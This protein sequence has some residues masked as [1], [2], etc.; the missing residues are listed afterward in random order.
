METLKRFNQITL[1]ALVIAFALAS[2]Q[3]GQQKSTEAHDEVA[4]EQETTEQQTVTV[5]DKEY[6]IPTSL[7]ITQ[8]INEAGASYIYDLCNSVENVDKYFTEKEKAINLGIYGADL[9][10]ASTYQRKQ[11][12]MLYLEASKKLID[13]LNVATAFNKELA[14]K[15]EMNIDNKDTLISIISESFYDTYEFLMD[16]GKDDLSVYILTG[17]WIEG[18]YLAT[19]LTINSQDKTEMKEIVASQ[20]EALEELLNIMGQNED[21]EEMAELAAKLGELK[22]EFDKI[23]EPMT[24]EQLQAIVTKVESIR[25][26]LI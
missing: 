23:S 19:Q 10:Y 6:P 24:D 20:K 7:E 22:T 13:D 25:N 3:S 15:V 8:M 2:C 12:T 4:T 18:L 9:S 16:N 21:N 11:E 17:S 1:I 5:A 14:N 26:E